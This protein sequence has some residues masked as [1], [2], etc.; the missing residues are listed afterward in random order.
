MIAIFWVN[1]MGDIK[2]CTMYTR[3]CGTQISMLKSWIFVF[4]FMRIY[5]MICEN[6]KQFQRCY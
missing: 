6:W 4:T 3:M 1:A 5:K 2:V